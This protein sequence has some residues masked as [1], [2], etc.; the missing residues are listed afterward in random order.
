L[1]DKGTDAG[2][3]IEVYANEEDAIKRN[4]Y[5]A[6]FDGGILSS[7]SHRVVGTVVIRISD[8]LTASQ[9]KALEEKV[10]NALSAL[11]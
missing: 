3:E 6:A 8:E 1:I 9:Q 7:R 2:G 5:L 11:Q 10:L 4:D